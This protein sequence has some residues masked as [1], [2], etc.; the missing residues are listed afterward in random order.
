MSTASELGLAVDDAVVL[1]DSNRLV[2]RLTPCDVVA[3][4]ALLT[5]LFSAEQ[6]VE[7]VKRLAETNSPVA[8]LEARVEP[9]VFLRDDFK[10]TLW[11]YVEPV[12]RIL[13]PAEYAQAL[14]RLHAGLRQIELTTPHFMERVAETEQWAASR[15]VTPDLNATDRALLVNALRDLGESVVNRRAAEQLLHGEPHPDNV[16][17]TKHGPLFIDFENTTRG[18][19]EYDLAW[20]PTEV[21][22]R[23]PD[24]DPDLLDEC[25]GIVLAIIAVSHS[26]RDDQ[27]PGN[28]RIAEWVSAVRDGPP[29]PSLDTV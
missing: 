15:D 5:H 28:T 1:N 16:L 4:V 10:I 24:I 13:P 6:E 22:D 25:R 7:L 17:D 26:R 20:V 21:S 9:R 18:P 8:T 11:T 3:R 29:W 23:Y 12:S 14:E 2:V 27:H 19:V